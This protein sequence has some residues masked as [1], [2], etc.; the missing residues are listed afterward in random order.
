MPF[1]EKFEDEHSAIREACESLDVLCERIDTGPFLGDIVE[2]IKQKIEACD[3]FVALLNDNN[4]NVFLELGYAWGKN[5]KTILIVE[6]VS[7][8]P[9][10]VKTKNAIVYKSRFKLREDMKRI[11]AETL[12]MKVVQ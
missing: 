3:I 2:K 1:A 9:F 8:L 5:K 7:G 11:L 4:P 6:D 12:S 10:D